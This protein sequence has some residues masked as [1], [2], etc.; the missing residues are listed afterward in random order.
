MRFAR[1]LVGLG[2]AAVALVSVAPIAAAHVT[3]DPSTAQ[4]GAGD[5]QFVFRV[6]NENTKAN[7]VK[8]VL[9]LDQMH[10]IADV[11]V[12]SVAGWTSEITKRHLAKA[13]TTDDGSFSDVA[14]EITWSGGKIGP[15]QFGE[16][17][18][19]AQG[20]PTDTDK[21]VFKAIQYYDDGSQVAWIQTGANAEHPAP[22][23]T[24][25]SAKSDQTVPATKATPT[26]MTAT[27]SSNNS[28][29]GYAIGAII[30]AG[31]GIVIAVAA[32]A[33]GLNR[34]RPD[35]N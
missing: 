25:T 8:L 2:V 24:L 26:P 23:V 16:F 7:T 11:N 19:L 3:P 21:L 30:L 20:L 35:T 15:G 33:T 12:L 9:Q 6:P 14:S 17:T 29:K 1:R 18:I 34:Q 28:G 4:K 31:I 22:V 13:I 5:Q 32:M 27:K 10:P